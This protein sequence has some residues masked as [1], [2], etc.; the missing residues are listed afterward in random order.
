MKKK[1]TALCLCISLL[2]V[3]LIG[4]TMAYFTDTDNA[5]NTFTVGNIKIELEEKNKDG[6]DF[7][8]D[9]IL[10][11]GEENSIVKNVFVTNK[12]AQNAYMWVEIWLPK[13]LAD[14]NNL[15][16]NSFNTY[17]AA[18]GTVVMKD[19]SEAAADDVLLA[20]TN[21]VDI[22]TKD[23]SNVSYQGYRINIVNDTPKAANASTASLLYSVFMDAGITQ[24]TVHNDCY[25]LL[26]GECYNGSPE[27]IVDAFGIQADGFDNIV[28][29]MT[30]YYTAA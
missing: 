4:G 26:N 24:C 10:M 13:K 12:G 25:K 16:F 6:S 23:I 7:T 3:A 14:Q 8:Q 22:G 20:E 9:Q 5:A 30:A 19:A 17:K 29:A 27:I 15:H 1:I 18:D 21:C 11:P 2:A 28:D